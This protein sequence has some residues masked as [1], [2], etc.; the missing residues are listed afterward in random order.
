MSSRCS[1]AYEAMYEY[2]A[3]LPGQSES[4]RIATSAE[5]YDD[6]ATGHL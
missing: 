4:Q 5:S 6:N 2:F 3:E 1:D